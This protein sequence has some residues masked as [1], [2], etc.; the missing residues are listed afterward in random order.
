MVSATRI[1]HRVNENAFFF[2]RKLNVDLAHPMENRWISGHA[3]VC[4]RFSKKEMRILLNVLLKV[5]WLNLLLVKLC[6]VDRDE[7]YLDL[8]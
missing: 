6:L 8:K 5:L 3:D 7:Y 4:D 2:D 1:T